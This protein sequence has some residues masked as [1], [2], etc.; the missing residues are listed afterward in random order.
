MLVLLCNV[1]RPASAVATNSGRVESQKCVFTLTSDVDYMGA[2]KTA[3]ACLDAK[4]PKLVLVSSGTTTRPD[5]AGFK[6]TNF[7][8][9]VRIGINQ[10]TF[11]VKM[12]Y[13]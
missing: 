13:G 12:L 2:Y 7:F 10:G 9:K 3:M 11:M 5:S 4:V 1:H 8:V 6:A